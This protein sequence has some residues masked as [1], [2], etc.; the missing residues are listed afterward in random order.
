MYLTED[1]FEKYSSKLVYCLE[2]KKNETFL[3]IVKMLIS[4]EIKVFDDEEIDYAV[5]IASILC[6]KFKF[7]LSDATSILNDID[8]MIKKKKISRDFALFIIRVSQIY[9]C[10]RFNIESKNNYFEIAE[11][12][13]NKEIKKYPLDCFYLLEK[14]NMYM[15]SKKK[16]L[17]LETMKEVEFLISSD[18]DQEKYD[19]YMET[20]LD[21]G[22]YMHIL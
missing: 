21:D 4:D 2:K 20:F 19:D 8:N 7:S 10:N 5:L 16:D 17:C 9:F 15:I 14:A 3:Q 12:A 13:I 22:Y 11:V 18:E 6:S 1:D